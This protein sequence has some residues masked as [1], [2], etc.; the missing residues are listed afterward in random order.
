[1][2]G[3]LRFVTRA[4]IKIYENGTNIHHVFLGGLCRGDAQQEIDR[5]GQILV[6]ASCQEKGF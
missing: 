2:V 6:Y 4:I 3:N 5:K 1:M